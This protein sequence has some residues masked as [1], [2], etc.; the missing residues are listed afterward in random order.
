MWAYIDDGFHIQFS[1]FILMVVIASRFVTVTALCYM[2][3]KSC[4]GFKMPLSE[5]IAFTLGMINTSC[6]FFLSSDLIL[7]LYIVLQCLLLPCACFYFLFQRED[8]HCSF[9]FRRSFTSDI[10][11]AA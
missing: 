6:N 11:S 1:M 2:C 4:R 3:S 9:L 7:V 10:L 8:Y 5:Q